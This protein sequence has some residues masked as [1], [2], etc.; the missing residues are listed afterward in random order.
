MEFEFAKVY[1]ADKLDRERHR[2][3]I[4]VSCL[5]SLPAMPPMIFAKPEPHDDHHH[6]RL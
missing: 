1:H 6:Y 4:S 2:L 5:D 3:S